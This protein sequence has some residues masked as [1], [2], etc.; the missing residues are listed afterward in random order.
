MPAAIFQ[1]A[2]SN[3]YSPVMTIPHFVRSQLRRELL[4]LF[5]VLKPHQIKVDPLPFFVDPAYSDQS[6]ERNTRTLCILAISPIKFGFCDIAYVYLPIIT[7]N[8]SFQH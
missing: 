2:V 7:R 1:A 4:Y 8:S 6:L 3:R 5:Q